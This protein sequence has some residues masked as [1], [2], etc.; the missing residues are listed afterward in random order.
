MH[1]SMYGSV[2]KLLSW[3]E[4][5]AK[6]LILQRLYAKEGS[7]LW[8]LIVSCH[9]NQTIFFSLASEGIVNEYFNGV[10]ILENSKYFAGPLSLLPKSTVVIQA[11]KL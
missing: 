2:P 6:A 11:D 5:D 1:T 8:E 7:N 9:D 4:T 10:I 3:S